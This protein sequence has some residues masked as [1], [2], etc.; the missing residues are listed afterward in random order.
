MT[1]DPR[2]LRQN[3]CTWKFFNGYRLFT[4]TPCRKVLLEK[5]KFPRLAQKFIAF[6]GTRRFVTAFTSARHLSSQ[7]TPTQPMSPP[8]NPLLEDPFNSTFPS[9]PRFSK[10][11]LPSGFPTKTLYALPPFSL[12]ATCSFPLILLDFI[13]I[14]CT[15]F[16]KAKQDLQLQHSK[17]QGRDELRIMN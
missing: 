3:P 2:T 17:S 9:T 1:K 11:S 15:N 12:Y 8:P 13:K 5:L 10:W 6:Y 4:P 7:T 16:T 14:I